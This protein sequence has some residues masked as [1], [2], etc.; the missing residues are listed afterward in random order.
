QVPIQGGM[1]TQTSAR[2]AAPVRKVFGVGLNKTGT[3]TL[4]RCLET[5]GYRHQSYSGA[6]LEMFAAGRR[7]ELVDMAAS[8]DSCADWPWPLLWREFYARYGDEARY[9]LTR[10]SSSMIW[11]ESLKAHSLRTHPTLAMRGLVYG[12]YY[13]HGYEAEHQSAYERHNEAVRKF[14]AGE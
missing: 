9:I 13:P 11:L 2:P 10:R 1:S 4:R 8:F 3:K 6:A 7:G 14:F 12:H 5:L